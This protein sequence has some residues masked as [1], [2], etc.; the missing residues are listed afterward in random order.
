[1]SYSVPDT[2]GQE[3]D[4]VGAG[5]GADTPLWEVF[6]RQRRGL[7]HVHVGS[8]MPQTATLLCRPPATSTRDEWRG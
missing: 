2:P 3:H 6:V 1:M 5:S 8:P 7:A 4:R